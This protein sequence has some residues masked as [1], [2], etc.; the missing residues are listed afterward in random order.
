MN[1]ILIDVCKIVAE[2]ISLTEFYLLSFELSATNLS[3]ILI[4]IFVMG[5]AGL[6]ANVSPSALCP[7]SLAALQAFTAN[8]NYR[9]PKVVTGV[10]Q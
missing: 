1:L 5:I 7:C 9:G 3:E 6:N 8:C 4:K 10:S 2:A